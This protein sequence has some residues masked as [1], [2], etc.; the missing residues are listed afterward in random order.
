MPLLLTIVIAIL[1]FCLC[2][3]IISIIP[4]PPPPFPAFIRTIL[5]IVLCIVAVCWLAAIGGVHWPR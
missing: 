2:W 4:L 5:Y 1:I 3:Y